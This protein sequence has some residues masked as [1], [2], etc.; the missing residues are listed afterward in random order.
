MDYLFKKK[1]EKKWNNKKLDGVFDCMFKGKESL[2][3]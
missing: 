1:K 3:Y 2:D